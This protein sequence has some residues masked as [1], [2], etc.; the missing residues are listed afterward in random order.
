MTVMSLATVRRATP[1]RARGIYYARALVALVMIAAWVVSGLT[2]LILWLMP[3]GQGSREI[4]LVAGLGRSEWTDIHVVAS[5]IGMSLALVHVTVM[6]RGVLAYLRLVLTGR[7]SVT[8][9]VRRLKPIVRVRATLVV[10]LLITVTL[11]LVSGVIPWLAADG[12]RS[13]RAVLLFALTK[14]DWADVH[15]VASMVAISVAA[16][17]VIVVRTGL[18]SDLRL[19]VTGRRSAVPPI[20]GRPIPAAAPAGVTA[21]DA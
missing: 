16:S 17:H 9:P 7:R 2:G 4:A 20:A 6:R 13:G 15:L 18:V 19:L 21:R 5:I 1:P 11:V 14:R 10:G 12:P 3:H 8:V